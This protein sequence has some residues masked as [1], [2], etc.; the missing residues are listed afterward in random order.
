ML[1]KHHILGASVAVVDHDKVESAGYGLARLPGVPFTPDTICRMASTSK[2]IGAAVMGLILEDDSKNTITVGGKEEKPTWS[3]TIIK[4][5]GEDFDLNNDHFD[6][7]VTI[8]DA[9]SNRS[10]VS[11]HDF[12]FGPWMGRTPEHM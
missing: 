8:E 4:I 11:G 12:N 3:T 5:L 10:G 1:D 7:N 9:L 6:K 2:A